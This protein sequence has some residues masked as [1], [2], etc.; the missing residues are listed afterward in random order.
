MIILGH[1]GMGIGEGENTLLSLIKADQLSDGIETDLRLTRDNVIVLNHDEDLKRVFNMDIKISDFTYKELKKNKLINDECLTTLEKLL[2][3]LKEK[4]IKN[5]EIKEY[6]VA[7]YILPLIKSFGAT[8]NVIISSFDYKCLEKIKESDKNIKIGL[9][10][11]EEARRN[12]LEEM[13]DYFKELIDKHKPYSFH[14]PVQM[15]E[16]FGFEIGFKFT[17]W[18]RTQGFKIAFWTVDDP[19]LALKIKDITD[20]F[21]TDNITGIK[22]VL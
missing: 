5:F 12:S 7:N 19:N 22:S 16:E 9:L 4:S 3:E 1:R 20:Y 6:N 17:K 13:S 10:V 11:G 18:L 8:D 15:F 14:L 21:I 2:L